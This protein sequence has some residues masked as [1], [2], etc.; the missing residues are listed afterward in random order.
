MWDFSFIVPSALM[1]VTLM[2]FYFSRPR[3]PLRLNRV[4][5]GL[6]VIEMLVLLVDVISTRIDEAHEL[7]PP[8][9]LY[10]ANTAFFVLY[11][12][13]IYWFFVFT[14]EILNATAQR[15]PRWMWLTVIPFALTELICLTSC[16]TGAV[17]SVQ[18]G[19][20]VSGPLYP[21]LTVT[22]YIYEWLSIILTLASARH[23]RSRD[24]IST[25]AYNLVLFA[26][27][28]IRTLFPHLLVMDTFCMVAI[29]I[30][31]L[32]FLNPD[33][34]LSDHGI[35]FN[36]RCFR[37]VLL[38][39][40][41]T[42]DGCLFGFALQNYNHER[43]I[44]GG[45]QTDEVIDGI[46][47]YLRTSFP[48]ATPFY[49]RGG[50]FA[51]V[52]DGKAQGDMLYDKV[53]KR[54]A[55]SWKIEGADLHLNALYTYVDLD[56]DASDID[57]VTNNFIIAL[58]SAR[59]SPTA[60]L[61]EAPDGSLNIQQIGEQ[62]DILRLLERAIERNEVEVFFQPLVNSR[63]YRVEG[64]EALARIRDGEGRLVSPG[65]F[66]PAAEKSGHIIELGEQVL[67]KT[68]EFAT[69]YDMD[70][71][72]LKWINVNLSP[73]QCMQKDLGHK[74][75]RILDEYSVAPGLIHLEVTEQTIADFALLRHQISA[76][77]SQGFSFVL[78]DYGTG[79]SNLTRVKHYPFTTIKLDMEVVWDYYRERD[80]LLPSIVQGFRSLG[81]SITAEGIETDE[82]ARTL[83][84]I[85]SDY[86]Q[87]YY[88]SKPLPV[89]EFVRTYQ[90]QKS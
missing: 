66:I 37:M 1:M 34:Y 51:L 47:A 2:A 25:Y 21:L 89:D 49:L 56:F 42:Q 84:E 4:F 63:T 41:R 23:F 33:L 45:D 5:L 20:Y 58:D 64:A 48:K 10:L 15:K 43:S 40:S 54:F 73:I 28:V 78:D 27:S 53:R 87:G 61:S 19:A 52:C 83:A 17:F 79:Y 82:M 72:G 57:S 59:Q 36:M 62:I 38:E 11:I 24:M 44:L 3:P 85:G 8:I 29:T 60:L 16:F 90:Q 32:S 68:C 88:F 86:L 71:L 81:L 18:D 67:R 35:A 6:L 80:N 12:L 13:R 74:F 65:L 46:C 55:G 26:G 77:E 39:R 31:Y 14:L 76:L 75:A 70:A 30:I 9:A 22:Y 7:F 69:S 50:R